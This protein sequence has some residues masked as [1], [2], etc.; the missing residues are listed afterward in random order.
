MFCNGCGQALAPG[1]GFCSQCGRPVTTAVPPELSPDFQLQKYANKVMTL[2][3]FWFFYAG[4]F[5][6]VALSQGSGF[7]RLPLAMNYIF[8]DFG[9]WSNGP[10][11]GGGS[12][13]PMWFAPQFL[14]LSE[15]FFVLRVGIALIASWGLLRRAQW[16]KIMAIVAAF[17]NILNFTFG[18]AMG[19]WTLIM[20]LGSRNSR[21]YKQ[22]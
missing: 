20:L 22:L 2:G 3:F 21:L 15:I 6:Y 4:L 9:P 11:S 1:K 10:W 12:L 18:T 7:A 17:L 13:P 16:G 8:S 5:I 14:Y 19:I